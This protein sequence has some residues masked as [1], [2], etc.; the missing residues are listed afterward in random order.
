MKD[1]SYLI[2][3]LTKK[4]V[5]ILCMTS[6]IAVAQNFPEKPLRV[7]VGP[8]PDSLA[9]ITGEK[10]AE[11]WGQ[12]VV[13]EAKPAAGGIVAG[14][15][16]AKSSPDGYTLLLSTGSFTINSVLQPKMPY[17]FQNDLAPVSLLATLPFVL[18]VNASSPIKSL[19]E[20]IASAKTQPGKLNYASSGS[21]TPAHLAGEMLKQMA[22][23]DILHIPYKSA[24]A[25]VTDLLGGQVNFM[26]VPAP[27]A[28]PF[29]KSNQLKALAVSSPKRYSVLPELPTVAEEGYPSFAIVGW[30]G[31]H[32]PAKTP[33]NI[34][35]K[36][37]KEFVKVMHQKEVQVKAIAAGFEPM[38]SS[39]EEF[40]QFVKS[41]ISRSSE[42]IKTGNIQPF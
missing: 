27:S 5:L 42:V 41:D 28:L 3:L 37:N 32:V 39:V 12:A 1:A 19:K 15:S 8:G 13:V 33:K 29:I 16:V 35:E 31:I 24:A 26:F 2:N 14:D 21:G 40:S 9:R 23:I 17:D 36:L 6:F 10:I 34:I 30:N 11:D 25:G 18:V 4:V 38:G 7:I 20:L 22:G